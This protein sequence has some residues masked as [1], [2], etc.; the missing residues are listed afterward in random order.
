M[1]GS[2]LKWSYTSLMRFFLIQ[3]PC[4]GLFSHDPACGRFFWASTIY[5]LRRGVALF[6]VF[7]TSVLSIFPT[8]ERSI[9][10]LECVC[11]GYKN[12]ARQR[13]TLQ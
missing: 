10:L 2:A 13:G 9:I 1:T 12:V 8:N 11:G 5:A 4:E 7:Q 6:V 3:R